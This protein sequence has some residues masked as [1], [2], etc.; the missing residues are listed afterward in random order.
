MQINMLKLQELFENQAF[1]AWMSTYVPDALAQV[2]E[3]RNHTD[4]DLLI[5]SQVIAAY[6][7]I[8]GDEAVRKK[9]R[10]FVVRTFPDAVAVESDAPLPAKL[11]VGAG[12][13]PNGIFP[14]YHPSLLRFPMQI[15]FTSSDLDQLAVAM[16]GF[17]ARFK[18]PPKSL[19]IGNYAYVEYVP[20]NLIAYVDHIPQ[21][22]WELVA[23]QSKIRKEQGKVQQ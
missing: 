14:N 22:N 16:K 8:Y 11:M 21:S 2:D 20:D 15:I 17:V 12:K 1:R 18:F 7:R 4:S 23:H 10:D 5:Q 9:F 3:A 6:N 13:D 19:I